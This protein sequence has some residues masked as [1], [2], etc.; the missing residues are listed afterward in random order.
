MRKSIINILEQII[1]TTRIL[2]ALSIIDVII[3][4]INDTDIENVVANIIDLRDNILYR[5]S[6]KQN[7]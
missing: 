7:D 1:P 2:L 6:F 5:L 4:K 3:F